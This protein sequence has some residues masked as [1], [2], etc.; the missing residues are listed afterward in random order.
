MILI[1]SIPVS[2]VACWDSM[3]YS[4]DLNRQWTMRECHFTR[5]GEKENAPLDARWSKNSA[6]NMYHGRVSWVHIAC[7]MLDL[8]EKQNAFVDDARCGSSRIAFPSPGPAD[9]TSSYRPELPG[10]LS[11]APHASSLPALPMMHRL[12]TPSCTWSSISEPSDRWLTGPTL[13]CFRHRRQQQGYE[14]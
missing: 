3:N 7:D 8:P 12:I 2:I 14:A 13:A 11:C 4:M 10:D 6:E 5:D 1:C 9:D